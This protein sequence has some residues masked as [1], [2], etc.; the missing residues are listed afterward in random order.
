MGT[1][2]SLK[3][4]SQITKILVKH[5]FKH[6]LSSYK[7][8]ISLVDKTELYQRLRL[9]LEELGPTFVKFGQILSNRVDLSSPRVDKRATKTPISS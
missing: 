8:K 4:F 9:V 6:L 2:Q 3:R 1:G 5:G 7:N